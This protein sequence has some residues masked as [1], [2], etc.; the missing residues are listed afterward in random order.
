MR[1]TASLALTLSLAA[2]TCTKAPAADVTD[3]AKQSQN[4]IADLV[5][6]PI[7]NNINF[8][9]G[10]DDHVQNTMNIQPVYPTAITENWLLINRC[11]F[12]IVNDWVDGDT[13]GLGDIQYQGYLSPQS[14]G[15]VTWGVGPVIQIPTATDALLGPREWCLGA[16]A[17][18]VITKDKWVYGGLINNT[19]SLD[20]NEVNLMFI[21]PF[22][23]YNLGKGAAVG[24]VPQI[25]ADW[26][27][28]SSQQWTVPLGAQV[29]KVQPVGKLPINW[30]L[31]AYGN[32]VKPDYAADWTLRLQATLMFP[33]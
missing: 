25:S 4:P 5:S 2:L 16:G 17:V 29:S 22:V 33:K 18:T 32:V 12:P 26:T 7:M 3:L 10:P 28:P 30:T 6:L 14:G 19:W 11:I 27:A 20:S 1:T 21:Q 8:E 24:F 23:N 9:A 13:W 31:G 15:D